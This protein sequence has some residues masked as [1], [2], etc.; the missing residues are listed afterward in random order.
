MFSIKKAE[1]TER[2]KGK[3]KSR[4]IAETSQLSVDTSR[5][6]QNTTPEPSSEPAPTGNISYIAA[7]KCSSSPSDSSFAAT[8]STSMSENSVSPP[9][10]DDSLRR[11]GV[12]PAGINFTE[13]RT[14]NLDPRNI[15]FSQNTV[16]RYTD[17][18][19]LE[20]YRDSGHITV[21]D[22]GEDGY[23]S[24]DSKRLRRAQDADLSALSVT[25]VYPA[26]PLHTVD[27]RFSFC[28]GFADEFVGCYMIKFRAWNYEGALYSRCSCQS[29][30]FPLFGSASQPRMENRKSTIIWSGQ[31]DRRTFVN[32]QDHGAVLRSLERTTGTIA[33][34]PFADTVPTV[35][36]TAMRAFVR[37]RAARNRTFHT[38][39]ITHYQNATFEAASEVFRDDFE[40]KEFDRYAYENEEVMRRALD[41]GY[42]FLVSR[43]T[44]TKGDS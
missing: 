24:L 8:T 13:P 41:E 16:A 11:R 32:E 39:E 34:M 23:V 26:T 19:C 17:A 38:V 12:I 44:R 4:Q 36:N 40:R 15:R 20:E 10:V 35:A 14:V 31:T 9:D 2:N 25:L 28:V 33:F 43:A 37:D 6:Q 21:V 3:D 1:G 7:L 27:K 22:L 30:D 18:F 29:D 5:E 42:D